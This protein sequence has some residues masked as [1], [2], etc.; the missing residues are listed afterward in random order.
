[1]LVLEQSQD[2][3][4][5]RLGQRDILNFAPR[6]SKQNLMIASRFGNSSKLCGC[7]LMLCT[8]WCK[9]RLSELFGGELRVIVRLYDDISDDTQAFEDAIRTLVSV[10][11]SAIAIVKILGYC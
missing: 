5:L 4:R 2:P 3:K 1:M 9:V 11:V 6:C 10:D 8:G 7:L